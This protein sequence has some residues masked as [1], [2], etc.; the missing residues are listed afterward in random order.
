[1]GVYGGVYVV[2]SGC[3]LGRSEEKNMVGGITPAP[4]LGRF[5]PALF[6]TGLHGNQRASGTVSHLPDLSPLL[7]GTTLG[8]SL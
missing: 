1:M 5:I 7:S 4:F 2:V 8:L 6:I 3:A